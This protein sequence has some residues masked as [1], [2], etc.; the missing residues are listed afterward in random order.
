M[1]IDAARRNFDWTTAT[2]KQKLEFV[3]RRCQ[4]ME[5]MAAHN[6]DR[7]VSL[8]ERL[9]ALKAELDRDDT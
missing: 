5:K 9:D 2:M 4:A 1:M 3:A 6:G 7:I 8:R